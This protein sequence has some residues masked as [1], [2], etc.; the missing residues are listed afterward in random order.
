[1]RLSH[2][3]ESSD[4]PV[5]IRRL[6]DRGRISIP[7]LDY[8]RGTWF[9]DRTSFGP[10]DRQRIALSDFDASRLIAT[11]LMDQL[12][13]HGYVFFTIGD[14]N[15]YYQVYET[16]EA[17]VEEMAPLVT[18]ASLIGAASVAYIHLQGFEEGK[19]F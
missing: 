15:E 2:G 12:L 10:Y 3:H 1:M 11:W 4:I 13:Y 17:F 8:W 14:N 7:K 6:Y 19:D 5:S 9:F 18:A 16:A